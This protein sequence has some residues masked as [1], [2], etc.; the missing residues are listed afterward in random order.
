MR[1]ATHI[2]DDKSKAALSLCYLLKTHR[3]YLNEAS[4]IYSE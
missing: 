3:P 4:Y 2:S 1:L